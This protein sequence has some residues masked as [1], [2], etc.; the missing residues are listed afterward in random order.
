MRSA[1]PT[2]GTTGQPQGRLTGTQRSKD[3]QVQ[4]DVIEGP[5]G[6]QAANVTIAA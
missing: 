4:F 2:S 1:L 6:L 3:A 5:K